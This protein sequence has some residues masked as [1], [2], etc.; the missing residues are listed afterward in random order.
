VKDTDFEKALERFE[1]S[2]WKDKANCEHHFYNGV[3]FQQGDEVYCIHLQ[4]LYNYYIAVINKRVE[5]QSSKKP[6]ELRNYL[7][8]KL[9]SFNKTKD[10]WNSRQNVLDA[11]INLLAENKET[12]FGFWLKCTVLQIFFL[13]KALCYLNKLYETQKKQPQRTAQTKIADTEKLKKYFY[14]AFKGKGNG[15]IDYF[16]MLLGHLQQRRTAKEI[17][18]IALMCYECASIRENKEPLTFRKWHKIFCDCTGCKYVEYDPCKLRSP[19]DNLKTTF[20]YIYTERGSLPLSA[21]NN[22]KEGKKRLQKHTGREE[23][24]SKEERYAEIERRLKEKGPIR[25]VYRS[26]LSILDN[27]PS[28]I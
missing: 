19:K 25:H 2:D 3:S 18:Q 22:Y 17:A 21:E 11:W 16:E 12:V 15:T 9:V 10:E 20:Y 1:L 23:P 28:D 14:D 13:D 26:P 6:N 8:I 4:E 5:K 7:K 27:Y 24:L